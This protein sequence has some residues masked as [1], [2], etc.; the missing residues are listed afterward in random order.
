MPISIDS[1]LQEDCKK[2]PVDRQAQ[3]TSLGDTQ[4]AS[5]QGHEATSFSMGPIGLASKDHFYMIHLTVS[6]IF[7]QAIE[8]VYF[9]KFCLICPSGS[10]ERSA[11]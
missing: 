7:M 1:V 8:R 6:L 2:H 3:S 5:G 11:Q 10:Q 4:F 9:C